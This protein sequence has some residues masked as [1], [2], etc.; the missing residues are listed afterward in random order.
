MW[1]NPTTSL[2]GKSGILK[3][4]AFPPVCKGILT[5][6]AETAAILC[7]C[8]NLGD[9]KQWRD[10]GEFEEHCVKAGSSVIYWPAASLVDHTAITNRQMGI[11]L[12]VGYKWPVKTLSQGFGIIGRSTNN[13]IWITVEEKSQKSNKLASVVG[14]GVFWMS[15]W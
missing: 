9:R 7:L 1:D 10:A 11:I 12:L 14:K 4:K 3:G 5:L 6:S 13:G 8:T 15:V 2:S